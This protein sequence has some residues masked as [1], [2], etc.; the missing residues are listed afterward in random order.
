M[1]NAD[2]ACRIPH[3]DDSAIVERVGLTRGADAGYETLWGCCAKTVDGDG[4]M[5]PPD[6]W[7]YEGAHTVC[8]FLFF[9]FI[10]ILHSQ[11]YFCLSL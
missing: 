11:F 8:L 9:S 10:P 6:G 2:T 1:E 7:C 4:D 5:G 3:D